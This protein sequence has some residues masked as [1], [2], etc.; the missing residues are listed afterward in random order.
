MVK[1]CPCCNGKAIAQNFV[2]EGSVKCIDCH[3]MIIKRHSHKDVDDGMDLAINI[4]N[5]RNGIED[6]EITSIKKY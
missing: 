3:L 2:I 1:N 5:K 4:W 6:K